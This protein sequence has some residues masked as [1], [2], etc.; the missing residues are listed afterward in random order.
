MASFLVDHSP[1]DP[2]LANV[3]A[4]RVVDNLLDDVFSA[5]RIPPDNEDAIGAS[6]VDEHRV[7]VAAR[8]EAAHGQAE[9]VGAA[10]GRQPERGAEIDSG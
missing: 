1:A 8:L 2:D 6:G 7:E 3:V 9:R 4:P 10:G 5:V